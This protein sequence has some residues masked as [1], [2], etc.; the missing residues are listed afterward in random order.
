MRD[1][2]KDETGAGEDGF[3]FFDKVEAKTNDYK[4]KWEDPFFRVSVKLVGLALLI[5]LAVN[6]VVGTAKWWWL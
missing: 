6:I 4:E 1:N 2:T 3:G 5:G